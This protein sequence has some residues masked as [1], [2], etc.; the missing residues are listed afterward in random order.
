M[1]R[2][3]PARLCDAGYLSTRQR[4]AHAAWRGFYAP[5]HNR[6]PRLDSAAPQDDGGFRGFAVANA[7]DY[8]RDSKIRKPEP[9][10]ET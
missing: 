3:T 8:V 7:T 4:R 1:L 2:V 10:D 9:L 6:R 5:V